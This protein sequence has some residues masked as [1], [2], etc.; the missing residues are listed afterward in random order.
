MIAVIQRTN[1]VKC[2]IDDKVTAESNKDTLMVLLG[3]K[4]DDSMEDI[5]YIVRKIPELR[6]FSDAD[7]KMNLSANDINASIFVVSQFT[8]HAKCRKGRRPN[9]MEAANYELGLDMYNTV[10]DKLN[11]T[12]LEILTGDFGADMNLI[13]NNN[14]PVTIILDSREN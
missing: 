5:D 10:V 6:I 14:G 13:F 11:E 9:F 2:V 12:N 7:G 1:G 3:I 8:L 4:N